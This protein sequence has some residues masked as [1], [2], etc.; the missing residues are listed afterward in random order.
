MKVAIVGTGNVG[1]ALGRS[2][3]RAGHEVT[4]AAR[5]PGKTKQVAAEL[6]A[7]SASTPAEAAEGAEVIILAVPYSAAED[8]AGEL[9]SGAANKVVVDVANPVKPDFSG[10][11]TSGGPSAAERYVQL[12]DGARVAKA[13]NTLF[14]TDQAEPKVHGVTLDGFFA[15]D[16]PDAR[17]KLTGLISSLGL[18]PVHVGPL[19]A[20]R[21]LESLAWLNMRLQMQHQGDWCSAFV[22]VDP[23]AGA[24]TAEREAASATAG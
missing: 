2:L 15:T 7:Q 10:L 3:V 23:P 17:Q 14:A 5:D 6:G 8:V 19:S 13:F 21:E 11:A 9:G 22:F 16:D 18:R 20:A 4:L 12:L 1:R 24:T